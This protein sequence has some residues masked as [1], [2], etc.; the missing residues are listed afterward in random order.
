VEEAELAA[1]WNQLTGLASLLSSF[2][3]RP[4]DGH[5]SN[6]LAR[7]RGLRHMWISPRVDMPRLRWQIRPS[8][9]GKGWK[10]ADI[11]DYIS[12]D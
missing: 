7:L 5:I 3:A 2:Q 9:A 10:E 4:C 11:A 12:D 1:A 6:R 8:Q